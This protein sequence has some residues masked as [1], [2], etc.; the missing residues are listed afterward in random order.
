[1]IVNNLKV[2]FSDKNVLNGVSFSL[3]NKDK[4]ALVGPNGSGKSTLLKSLAGEL[5]VDSG[6][7]KTF[8]E[9]ISY[10][11]QEIP[12]VF[13]DYSIIE[14]I[15]KEI[16]IDK[17]EKRL[18]YLEAN[19][20]EEN[21]NE[22]GDIINKFLALD[23]YNF[24]DNLKIVLSG[25]HFDN[26]LETKVRYLSGGE[27]IKILIAILLLKNSDI[28]LLDE[29]TNNL[30][31]EAILWLEN[32]LK[33]SNKKMIIVSHDE[34][35]LNNIATK[36]FELNEGKISEYNL[37]YNDYLAKKEI[38]YKRQLDDYTNAIEKKEKLKKQ[39]TKANEWAS[40]GLNKKAHSDNDKI[41]NN[42]A[43][44]RTNTANLGK[45][46]K[47][48]NEIDIPNFKEKKPINV[49]FDLDD[50]K[51]NKDIILDNLVCG[52]DNFRTKSITLSIP[53]GTKIRID[54]KNG[55]GKTTFV[56]TILCEIQPISGKVIIGKNVKIGYISQDTLAST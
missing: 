31:I 23:G 56:K 4:I 7:I 16:G 26:D 46:S 19:L 20:S 49:V 50:S 51:G 33:L 8:G 12:H 22:Y 40:R 37:G 45:L 36:I 39:L 43:K 10:L 34:E 14:F 13:N 6:S 1:M 35:F 25:L 38:E 30:D 11:K 5:I 44:E 18:N 53:F 41:A 52:Y 54:G 42:F 28:L 47:A 2:S 32:Y 55:S 17:L 27:K 15:K 3:N 24:E 48:L 29:P 21:M 9:T